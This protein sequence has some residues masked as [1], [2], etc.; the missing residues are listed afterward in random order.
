[1][2]FIIKAKLLR[3]KFEKHKS[4]K[5]ERKIVKKFITN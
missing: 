2:N 4:G 1:M 5:V 3:K